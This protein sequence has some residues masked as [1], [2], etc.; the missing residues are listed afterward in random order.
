MGWWVACSS[1]EACMGIMPSFEGM[2]HQIWFQ[3]S[4]F[5]AVRHCLSQGIGTF[6]DHT[7]TIVSWWVQQVIPGP[8]VVWDKEPLW[9]FTTHLPFAS[10]VLVPSLLGKKFCRIGPS[11][12]S[13]WPILPWIISFLDT[14]CAWIWN[15]FIQITN[16]HHNSSK[17]G[18]ITS[19][20]TS[21]KWNN[22]SLNYV[23]LCM[24]GIDR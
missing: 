7:G 15:I 17:F 21:L 8:A 10:H 1:F 16:V 3:V 22:F 2:I 14:F 24:F 19:P 20:H 6:D 4:L 13:T 12:T 23:C 18:L 9:T 5:L 11:L